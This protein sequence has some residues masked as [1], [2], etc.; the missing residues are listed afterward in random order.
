[1]SKG[2]VST[3]AC[4]E[5][6]VCGQLLTDLET[7][8]YA[9]FDG[10]RI[11]AN[12]VRKL[13]QLSRLCSGHSREIHLQARRDAVTTFRSWAHPN[14]RRN[15]RAYRNVCGRSLECKQNLH[16]VLNSGRVL[17]CVRPLVATLI[18]RGPIWE[19][20]DQVQHAHAHSRC[21]PAEL[22]FLIPSLDRLSISF[23]RPAYTRN[24][25][26]GTPPPELILCC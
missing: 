11:R 24:G 21:R 23:V 15:R 1:V 25:G 17:T 3:S 4:L 18:R 10:V 19:F 13:H 22:V 5:L 14:C 20:A 2:C 12:A 6:E 8:V 7:D 9:R 26:L 16:S